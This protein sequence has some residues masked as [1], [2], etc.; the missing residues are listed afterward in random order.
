MIINDFHTCKN[1][2]WKCKYDFDKYIQDNSN[3]D[4]RVR[5]GFNYCTSCNGKTGFSRT[6]KGM[7]IVFDMKF[8]H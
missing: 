1:Q 5:M 8:P 2:Q 4:L 7:V 6:R 3:V